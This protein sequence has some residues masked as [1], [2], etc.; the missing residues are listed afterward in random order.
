MPLKKVAFELWTVE[1]VSDLLNTALDDGEWHTPSVTDINIKQNNGYCIYGWC[2]I[3]R[4]NSYH[5]VE[6]WFNINSYSV[7]I[8]KEE[9][10]RNRANVHHHRPIYNL[11][12]IVEKL[13]LH[14]IEQKEG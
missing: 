3:S 1:N 13:K 12:A 4:H 8:W 9:Y 7:Q 14:Q 2:N 11:Q 10:I 6:H 5:D